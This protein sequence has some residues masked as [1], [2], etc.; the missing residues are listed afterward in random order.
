MKGSLKQKQTPQTHLG[1]LYYPN[2]GFFYV[3][4]AVHGLHLIGG[5]FALGR[6]AIRAFG[7]NA[8]H[9]STVLSIELCAIYW[10]YLLVI[11][12]TLFALILAT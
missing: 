10:H 5:L 8:I 4:T 12:L 6:S 3:I 11:W 9:E 7:G 1:L 2:N